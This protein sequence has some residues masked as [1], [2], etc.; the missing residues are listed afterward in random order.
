MCFMSALRYIPRSTLYR[1][2]VI[3]LSLPIKVF[4][5]WQHAQLQLT[6]R[7]EN[8]AKIELSGRN[9]KLDQAQKEVEE[10]YK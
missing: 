1:S 4:Q 5:N 3:D 8:K 10:V 7:R 6:K 2:T 9:E